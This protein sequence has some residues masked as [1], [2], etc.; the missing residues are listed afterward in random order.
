MSIVVLSMSYC[1]SCRWSTTSIYIYIYIIHITITAQYDVLLIR[2]QDTYN[3]IEMCAFIYL[4]HTHMHPCMHTCMHWCTHT[5]TLLYTVHQN[6]CTFHTKSQPDST[7]TVSTSPQWIFKMH[8]KNLVID[9]VRR[10]TWAQWVG[11][12]VENSA[13]YKSKQHQQNDQLIFKLVFFSH[14]I[15]V[16]KPLSFFFLHE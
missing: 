4:A 10:A 1:S 7:V 11:S 3:G 6:W 5:H 9:S 8:Y 2:A 13:T 15:T 14:K 16:D 12:R